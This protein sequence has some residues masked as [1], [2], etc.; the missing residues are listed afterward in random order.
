MR[1]KQEIQ[2]INKAVQLS[3]EFTT[4]D[5]IK[6]E[7]ERAYAEKSANEREARNQEYLDRVWKETASFR[8]IEAR[9]TKAQIKALRKLGTKFDVKEAELEAQRIVA[10][11][12]RK[13]ARMEA[14]V[15]LQQQREEESQMRKRMV[16]INGKFVVIPKPNEVAHLIQEPILNFR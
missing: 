14:E 7:A 12:E 4:V 16:V 9:L 1:K 5:P 10:R 11:M 6:E 15:L 13:V 2:D 3:V 8:T